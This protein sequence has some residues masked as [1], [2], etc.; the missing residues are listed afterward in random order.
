MNREI[1]FRGK[2]VDSGIW[3]EGDLRQEENFVAILPNNQDVW[4]IAHHGAGYF[5][6]IPETVGQYTGLQDLHGEKIFVGDRI[7]CTTKVTFEVGHVYY[8]FGRFCFALNGRDTGQT[9]YDVKI[10]SEIEII[11]NIHEQLKE[12]GE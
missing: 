10:F 3:A 8:S 9:L 2:N 12:K 4:D 5:E 7:K 6:V 1:L 11:G